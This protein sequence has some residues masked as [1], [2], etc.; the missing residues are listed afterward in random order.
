MAGVLG[1]V[2]CAPEQQVPLEEDASSS[3]SASLRLGG[4]SLLHRYSFTAGGTDSVSAAHATLE[5]GAT[6]ANGA[7]LLSGAGA[8]VNLPITGTLASLHDATF[9]AWVTWDSASGQMWARIFDFNDG[10]WVKSLFLTPSN[11]RFDSGPKTHTPRFGITTQAIS[12]EEQATSA[13]MF[14]TGALT[15]VAV[16]MDSIARVNRLYINGM[17]VA[18]TA[19]P[20]ALTPASLGTLANA[21]LGRS[22][23]SADPFF[24]GSISEFRVHG[25]ALS[26]NDVT[27]SYQ[28]GPDAVFTPS[29]EY[30][31]IYGR[32]DIAGMAADTTSVY[33][34]EKR[35]SGQVMKASLTTGRAQVLASNRDNPSAVTTDATSV[36]WVEN[37]TA[38]FKMPVN[39]GSITLLAS[40]LS[41][42]GQLVT[43][44]AEL[45]WTQGGSIV[46]MPVQGG[47][48][49]ILYTTALAGPLAVDGH[50][51]YWMEPDGTVVKAARPGGPAAYLWGASNATTGIASDGTDLFIAENSSPYDILRVPVGGAQLVPAFSVR[52]G[53]ITSLAVGPNRVAWFDP[54]LGVILAKDK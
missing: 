8:Y 52:Y 27:G 20:T 1:L 34:V 42:I 38:L 35:T 18:Q 15:H 28:A 11:G 24:K 22:A 5:G 14:P 29:A 13:A 40:G 23:Y 19:T 12:G 26:P 48:P 9:E 39:G 43:D 25:A 45:F 32:T 2:G 3:S 10:D 41:G 49:A 50:H 36:Y 31:V 21:W 53:S 46:H 37:G 6:T 16:T 33:W 54:S 7:V 17:Q 30:A 51:L 44:G 4:S 47:T